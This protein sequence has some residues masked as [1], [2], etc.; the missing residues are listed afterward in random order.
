VK[1]L[2]IVIA[3]DFRPLSDMLSRTLSAMDGIEVVGIAADG[4]EA[5]RLVRELK[6]RVLILDISMPLKDGIQVLREI[7]AEDTSTVII[8]FT[9]ESSL[10]LRTVCQEEGANYFL[11]KS[12]VKELIEICELELLA[13]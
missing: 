5:L 13:R 10:V 2:K 9:G 12:Q 7:R 11:E 4:V 1:Q 3:E 8:M 6:P